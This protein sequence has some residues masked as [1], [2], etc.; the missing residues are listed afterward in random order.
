MLTTYALIR[1]CREHVDELKNVIWELESEHL[2][3]NSENA[4]SINTTLQDI[5]TKLMAI[6]VISHRSLSSYK[7]PN[8][9]Q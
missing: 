6:L 8:T 5:L 3:E 4:E 7:K 9:N 2:L 1:Y